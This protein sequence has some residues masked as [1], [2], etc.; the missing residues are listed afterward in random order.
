[1]SDLARYF[2]SHDIVA[3]WRAECENASARLEIACI[4]ERACELRSQSEPLHSLTGGDWEMR[5]KINA[6]V[7]YVLNGRFPKEEE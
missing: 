7:F 6:A 4:K 3:R 5:D 1:M 2:H